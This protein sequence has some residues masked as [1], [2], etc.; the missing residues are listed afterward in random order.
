MDTRRLIM[1]T[2]KIFINGRSQAVRL[3]KEFRFSG[4]DVFIKKIGKMVV[5][6]PK[7]DPWAS[8]ANSLNQ[9][10]DDFMESRDQPNQDSRESF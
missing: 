9:F 6:I 4:K 5:L 1:Q 10:T 8:L 7:D 2:A 3:P